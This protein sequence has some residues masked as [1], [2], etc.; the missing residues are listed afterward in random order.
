MRYLCYLLLFIAFLFQGCSTDNGAP[1]PKTSEYYFR[2]KVDGVEIEYEFTP[3]SYINLTGIYEKDENKEIYAINIAGFGNI[4]EPG[5]TNYLSIFVSDSLDIS[6]GVTYS[7]IPGE[8]DDFPDLLFS[9]G[10]V[11]SEGNSYGAAA[12]GDNPLY[13]NLYEPAFVEFPEIADTYIS[14]TFSG[15]LIWYDTS[16]GINEFVDSVVVSEG[17]FKVPRY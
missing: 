16:T 1:D 15:T 11:D 12:F 4:L 14:G 2:F 5:T 3:D 10:Y 6:T 7:N 17:E 9:M 8:G 13:S